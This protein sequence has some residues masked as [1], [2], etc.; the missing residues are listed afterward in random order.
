MILGIG[1]SSVNYKVHYQTIQTS[2]KFWTAGLISCAER[3]VLLAKSND[4]HSSNTKQTKVQ[5]VKQA[6][7]RSG[8]SLGLGKWACFQVRGSRQPRCDKASGTSV[9]SHDPPIP[10]TPSLEQSQSMASIASQALAVGSTHTAE[11]KHRTKF[12][13]HFNAAES[14]NEEV[15][16]KQMAT[17]T[18]PVYQ[19]FKMPPAIIIKKGV[20]V[21]VYT[22]IAYVQLLNAEVK[23]D[24]YKPK[25]ARHK[26]CC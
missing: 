13:E 9:T 5:D 20:V 25:G 19:H 24:H 8:P 14:T 11:D 4:V 10:S 15:L 6:T 21:Y 23:K 26:T 1:K 16:E 22:C 2:P 12:D 18:S 17:W 3:T 7:T